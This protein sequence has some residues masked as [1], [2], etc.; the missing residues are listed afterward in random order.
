LAATSLHLAARHPEIEAV[1]TLSTFSGWKA[2]ASDFVPVV[3]P[4]LIRGG[5]DQLEAVEALS[6]RHYFLAHG[7][8]DE[9]VNYRHFGILKAAAESA[10]AQVTAMTAEGADHNNVLFTHP[11][12]AQAIKA[13]FAERLLGGAG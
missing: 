5:Q 7:D 1:A 11:E 10:G 3:G 12:V 8:A 4:L 6:G 9:I 2:V 13:F